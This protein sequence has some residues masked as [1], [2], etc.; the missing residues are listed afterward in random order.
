MDSYII[1]ISRQALYLTLI[2]TAAPVGAALIVGLLVSLL[3]A[4]TQIQEQT[5]TFVPKLV[6]IFIILSVLGP[7][8]FFQVVAFMNNLIE[9]IPVYIK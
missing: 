3:Q 6:I 4:T 8:S 5:L 9:N 1:S 2:L 7:W